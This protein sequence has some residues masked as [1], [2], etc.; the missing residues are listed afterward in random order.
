MRFPKTTRWIVYT[1]SRD[2]C[3]GESEDVEE[4][5]SWDT[6]MAW[7]GNSIRGHVKRD[8]DGLIV[9]FKDGEGHPIEYANGWGPCN[10]GDG[11]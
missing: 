10:G 1:Y 7:L 3:G 6:A 8:T 9:A 5:D 2:F 11:E 4:T